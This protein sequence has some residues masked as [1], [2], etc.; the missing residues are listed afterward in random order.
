MKTFYALLI[1]T[2]FTTVACGNKKDEPAK[3][4]EPAKTDPAAKTAEPPKAEPPAPEPPKAEPPKAE[5]SAAEVD[6]MGA[7]SLAFADKL[8]KV[9]TDAGN[10]CAKLGAGLKTMVDEVK[11]NAELEKEFRKN[12][13]NKKEFEDKY[14]AQLD[15][16][17]KDVQKKIEKCEKNADVKAFLEAIPD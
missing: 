6:Q 3:T 16:K 7:T 4:N 12:A 11:K 2:L 17:V 15:A 5:P 9:G 14:Q 8:A 10:D 13:E 1:A